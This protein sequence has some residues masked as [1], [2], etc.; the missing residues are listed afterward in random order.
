M[1]SWLPE[2]VYS[3]HVRLMTVDFINNLKL[4]LHCRSTCNSH[5]HLQCKR[6]VISDIETELKENET[7]RL[8]LKELESPPTGVGQNRRT[9]EYEMNESFF[10]LFFKRQEFA[11]CDDC[12]QTSL[13]MCL[14]SKE[15][16]HKGLCEDQRA[17]IF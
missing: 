7:N 5:K 6:V 10:W 13:V 16:V 4:T 17:F 15:N 12:F 3:P 8:R 1:C 9:H 2:G 14:Q 11:L